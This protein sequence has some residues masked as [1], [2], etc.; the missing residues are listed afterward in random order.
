MTTI[1][2]R[3]ELDALPIFSTVYDGAVEVYQKLPTVNAIGAGWFAPGDTRA[4]SAAT[5]ELPARL[6]D[7]GP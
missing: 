3:A 7:A 2:T 6:L 5:I 1:N 4:Y